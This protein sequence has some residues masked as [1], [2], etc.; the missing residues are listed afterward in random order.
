MRVKTANSGN[1]PA[2]AFKE[3]I[4]HDSIRPLERPGSQIDQDSVKEFISTRSDKWALKTS[5]QCS[6]PE[7][8]PNF[9]PFKT[10]HFPKIN[11]N[12]SSE[13]IL[14]KEES[15][16]IIPNLK[17][18][19]NTSSSSPRFIDKKSIPFIRQVNM[20]SVLLL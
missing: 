17:R 2:G 12:Q 19:I 20:E 4:G 14:G 10:Y 3:F 16:C 13:N 6:S 7:K 11:E 1:D 8:L 18:N 5:K 9:Q 15:N